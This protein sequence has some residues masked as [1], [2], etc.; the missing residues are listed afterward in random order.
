M[1]EVIMTCGKICSGKSTYAQKLAAERNA[2]ILSV[3]EITLEL[4]PEGAGE[5]LDTY[6]E[7]AERC[8]YRKSLEILRTGTNVV[9][10]WG[11]W[12]RAEREYARN[13]YNSRNIAN[14]IHYLQISDELWQE[15]INT[16]NEQINH[17]SEQNIS[18]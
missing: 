11:L 6:V 1:A 2:V 4:F 15:R 16:R 14:E 5:M 3:E 8:L 9:L 17:T 12:T 13:F 18:L 10:D 7:R